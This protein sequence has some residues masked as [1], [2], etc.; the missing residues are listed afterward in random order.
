MRKKGFTLIELLVVIA[1]IAI[2]AAILLPALAR[3]R[4]AAR[5]ASCMNNL[6]QYGIIHKMFAG[7]NR[8]LWVWRFTHYESEASPTIS[9]WSSFDGAAL[10]PDYLNDPNINYCPSD[11]E[12]D[13]SEYLRNPMQYLRTVSTTWHTFNPKDST[14]PG[15]VR[16]GLETTD[17]QTGYATAGWMRLPDWSYTYWSW[18]VNPDW[19]VDIDDNS[20]VGYFLDSDFAEYRDRNEDHERTLPNYGPVV[21]LRL[22]E[23]VE[24]FMITNIDNPASG[25]GGQSNVAVMYDSAH[26]A[27]GELDVDEYNHIP[28]GANVLFQDGHVEF[29][30]F[31]QPEGSK[32]W[33][34][35]VN[36]ATN[37][38]FYF[39]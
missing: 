16:S 22:R 35:T 21:F 38:F 27:Q 1:I 11:G 28:G 30:R 15:C 20:K 31:P 14:I 26:S 2:L 19:C 9:M 13:G 32:F 17:P 6:K 25:M 5:R 12:T 29:S 33:N 18:M 23:G 8:E 7:E 36:G 34:V 24:R 3:A 4:E 10:Y 37:G 39:P